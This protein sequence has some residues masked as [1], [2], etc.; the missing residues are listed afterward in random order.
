MFLHT[1]TRQR[2]KAHTMSLTLSE[3]AQATGTNRTTILRA[4]KGGRISGIKDDNGWRVE[5]AEL[6]RVY[7]LE[8]VLERAQQT[9]RRL[10]SA[11]A[12]LEHLH[13]DRQAAAQRRPSPR[14]Q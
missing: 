11:R 7:A 6:F 14:R 10:Q 12:R 13:R 5:A 2:S 8:T 1:E 9:S 4:V 3:A